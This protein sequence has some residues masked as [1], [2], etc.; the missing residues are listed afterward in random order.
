MQLR[1]LARRAC[2]LAH[3]RHQ[4]ICA[5]RVILVPTRPKPSGLRSKTLNQ[6]IG[7]A[8]QRNSMPVPS[9]DKWGGKPENPA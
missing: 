7:G 9:S 5:Y 6:V 8:N 4:S 3:S 1:L 2:I